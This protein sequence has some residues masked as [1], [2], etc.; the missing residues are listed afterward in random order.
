M[1]INADE[2]PAEFVL[3][4]DLL[5]EHIDPK[6]DDSVSVRD[7]FGVHI[8]LLAWLD[9]EWLKTQLVNFFPEKPLRVQDK[10]AWKAFLLF[11]QPVL[12]HDCRPALGGYSDEDPA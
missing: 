1:E 7:I 6:R 4:L 10:F 5:E 2:L 3:A 12:A 8:S 9:A 11:D